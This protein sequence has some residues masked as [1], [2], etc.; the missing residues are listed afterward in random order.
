MQLISVSSHFRP[1]DI[2]LGCFL[3]K[4]KPV[5]VSLKR[6]TKWTE[7]EI[8]KYHN[9][10]DLAPSPPKSLQPFQPRHWPWTFPAWGAPPCVPWSSSTW[11]GWGCSW[12]LDPLLSRRQ[13]WR[14]RP[15][16]PP[17]Q[18]SVQHSTII[19]SVNTR[20]NKPLSTSFFNYCLIIIKSFTDNP[21][22][23]NNVMFSF[24]Q[25]GFDLPIGLI[26]N[27]QT[28]QLLLRC[29]S[30]N[31]HARFFQNEQQLSNHLPLT[32]AIGTLQCYLRVKM[33]PNQAHEINTH[34]QSAKHRGF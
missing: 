25:T 16:P 4:I 7:S 5:I 13:C 26:F 3:F 23:M 27:F 1:Q 28:E 20:N 17:L 19:T 6:W 24:I 29:R 14:C 32:E 10:T 31:R 8:E 34:T 30:Y 15:P 33:I 21:P 11:A 22:L 18:C 2:N 9:S 12:S